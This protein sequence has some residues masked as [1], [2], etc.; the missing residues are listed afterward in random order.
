LRIDSAFELRVSI[1]IG[2][3]IVFG[4]VSRLPNPPIL[5][6]ELIDAVFRFECI[7]SIAGSVLD[8]D[9]LLLLIQLPGDRMGR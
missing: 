6:G 9:R 5:N 2:H 1:A 7:R 3:S 8:A 4:R